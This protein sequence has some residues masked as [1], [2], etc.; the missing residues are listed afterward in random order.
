LSGS[1]YRFAF[2]HTTD[3][4]AS[5][6][7]EN[8]S[9]AF[10]GYGRCVAVSPSSP[11]TIYLGGS[12]KSPAAPR[13]F[14]STDGGASWTEIVNSGWSSDY[15]LYSIAVHPANPNTVCASTTY[16]IYRTTNGGS[17][18][19]R[20]GTGRDYGYDMHWSEDDVSTIF[21]GAKDYV[22][23]S[24][25]GG[26]SWT[27]HSSGLSTGMHTSL[28]AD[29]NNSANVYTVSHLG[30]YRSQ[31]TATTWDTS[32][33]GLLTADILCFWPVEC[34]PWTLYIS[35]GTFGLYR[36]TNDGATLDFLDTPLD[37]GDVCAL[38]TPSG[39]PDRIL[40][41]EGAG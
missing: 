24:L 32:N 19:S 22:Y 10:Q 37:C 6:T 12:D 8:V 4:G 38:G 33:G 3:G 7:V 1:I 36:S 21:C 23:R 35:V 41:L 17:S 29:W 2:A 39:D 16:H 5:W 14:R 25:N 40:A 31:N 13:M 11:G 26:S 18:W 34:S 30:V 27:E 15:Y 9:T 20:T 28:A